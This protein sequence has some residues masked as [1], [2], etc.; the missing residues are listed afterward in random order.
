MLS[1]FP[2]YKFDIFPSDISSFPCNLYFPEFLIPSWASLP[3][4]DSDFSSSFPLP[5]KSLPAL[6]P[7]HYPS[8]PLPA[9]IHPSLLHRLCPSPSLSPSLLSSPSCSSRQL[10]EVTDYNLW[11]NS[12]PNIYLL[13]FFL[14]ICSLKTETWREEKGETNPRPPLLPSPL[15]SLFPSLCQILSF[16]SMF[17]SPIACLRFLSDRWLSVFCLILLSLPSISSIVVKF[18]YILLVSLF[19]FL[20]VSCLPLA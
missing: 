3:P 17:A 9:S 12:S 1:F 20:C 7:L 6:L 11:T 19:I 2:L 5:S 8:F 15:P 10:V 13:H 4:P 14:F 18:P 16:S